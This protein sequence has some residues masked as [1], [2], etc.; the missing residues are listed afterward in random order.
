ML[1]SNELR[2]GNWVER[3]GHP[4][5]VTGIK[6]DDIFVDANGVELEYYIFDGINPIPITEEWF[7]KFGFTFDKKDMTELLSPEVKHP[8]KYIKGVVKIIEQ[9]DFFVFVRYE[10]QIK[11]VHQLQNLY[12]ALTGEE[13]EAI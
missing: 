12:F 4:L 9:K 8:K 2:Q 3:I 10:F 6:N 5:K 7:L 13:L 11:Y 1:F